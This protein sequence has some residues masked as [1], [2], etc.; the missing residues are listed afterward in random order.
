MTYTMV[1][2]ILN[3]SY[4]MPQAKITVIYALTI[5]VISLKWVV[6][7]QSTGLEP[8]VIV[9]I[10]R[11]VRISVQM[12]VMALGL[13]IVQIVLPQLMK[14]VRGIVSVMRTGQEQIVAF[15]AGLRSYGTIHRPL[16]MKEG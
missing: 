12:A 2:A 1:T 16:I 10:Q 7:V 5:Q 8:T 15:I 3:V 4:A 11:L 14:T 9:L 6:L 13:M